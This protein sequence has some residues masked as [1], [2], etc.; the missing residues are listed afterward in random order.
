MGLALI[1]FLLLLISIGVLFFIQICV[2]SK[3]SHYKLYMSI[4]QR[5]FYN[6]FIRYILQ[7]YLKLEIATSTAL[8]Y[9]QW[10]KSLKYYIIGVTSLVGVV[11]LVLMPVLFYYILYK[12]KDKLQVHSVKSKIGSLYLG[13]RTDKYS[14]LFY[15]VVFLLRRSLFVGLTWFLYDFPSLQVHLFIYSSLL[16]IITINHLDHFEESFQCK[17]ELT[18]ETLFIVICYHLVYF[19]NIV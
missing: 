3:Y 11:L 19:T 10:D 5:I 15:L 8:F 14:Q 2:L 18:N 4:K 17:V 13:M 12:Q 7:S 6:A 1:L 9:A 16:Y